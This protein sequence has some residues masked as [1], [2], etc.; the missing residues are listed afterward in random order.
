MKEYENWDEQYVNGERYVYDETG[1]LIAIEQENGVTV[2][3]DEE[4]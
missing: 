2:Y 1:S 4:G 3:Y